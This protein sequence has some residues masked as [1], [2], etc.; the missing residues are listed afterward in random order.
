[1][2]VFIVIN[3][4]GMSSFDK[5]CTIFIIESIISGDVNQYKELFGSWDNNASISS[6]KVSLNMGQIHPKNVSAVI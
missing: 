1:M 5:N 4:L 6:A 3:L 2:R